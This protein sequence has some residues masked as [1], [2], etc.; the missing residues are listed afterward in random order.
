LDNAD[1]GSTVTFKPYNAKSTN[2]KIFY[3]SVL[4]S[5]RDVL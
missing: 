4:E 1:A 2:G 3:Y 5:S